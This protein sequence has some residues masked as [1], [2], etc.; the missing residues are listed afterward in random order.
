MDGLQSDFNIDCLFEIQDALNE[1][2]EPTETQCGNYD[3]N[4][5]RGY[6]TDCGDFLCSGCQAAHGKTKLTKSHQLIYTW[7]QKLLE[8][9]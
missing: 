8:A 6:C 2:A 9:P 5:A 1:A 3:D 4:K 7:K